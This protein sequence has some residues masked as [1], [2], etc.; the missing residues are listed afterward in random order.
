MINETPNHIRTTNIPAEIQ[1]SIDAANAAT[2]AAEQ[3]VRESRS[4]ARWMLMFCL[5][6]AFVM[7]TIIA[8]KVVSILRLERQV[9]EVKQRNG[10]LR[11]A[12]GGISFFWIHNGERLSAPM[13]MN[14]T[15]KTLEIEDNGCPSLLFIRESQELG[16]GTE[17]YNASGRCPGSMERPSPPAPR[18]CPTP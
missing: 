18:P 2:A 15:A 6:L 13:Q 12:I 8:E 4:M 17:A 1:A 11:S 3:R 9:F 7:A 10:T 16:I 14:R 5:G